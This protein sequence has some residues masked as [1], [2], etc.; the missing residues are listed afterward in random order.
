MNNL[1]KFTTAILLNP[2][3][4]LPY[5]GT[6]FELINPTE[7]TDWSFDDVF[8]S[9]FMYGPGMGNDRLLLI[10]KGDRQT[11]IILV[12]EKGSTI[13][14]PSLSDIEKEFKEVIEQYIYGKSLCY[15]LTHNVVNKSANK[16]QSSPVKLEIGNNCP[17]EMAMDEVIDDSFHQSMIEKVEKNDSASNGNEI[18]QVDIIK[19]LDDFL[20]WNMINITKG[21]DVLHIRD[22]EYHLILRSRGIGLTHKEKCDLLKKQIE[23]NIDLHGNELHIELLSFSDFE[24]ST[25]ERKKHYFSGQRC[26]TTVVGDSNKYNIIHKGTIYSEE[27]NRDKFISFK[28]SNI[29]KYYTIFDVF[30]IKLIPSK[31]ESVFNILLD[32]IKNIS[33]NNSELFAKIKCNSTAQETYIIAVPASIREESIGVI[34]NFN[35]THTSLKTNED[36]KNINFKIEYLSSVDFKKLTVDE[37]TKIVKKHLSA[38]LPNLGFG[39]MSVY[40]LDGMIK[41]FPVHSDYTFKKNVNVNEIV[42]FKITEI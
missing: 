34:R 11:L 9:S 42:L 18:T 37:K 38:K 13:T 32:E 7:G 27:I 20:F 40:N 17:V 19:K 25:Q 29:N 15:S 3:I 12:K 1:N 14:N 22:K 2:S 4:I 39:H 10:S 41:E 33:P 5:V 16:S 26:I 36:W 28:P 21:E 6:L 24:N 8:N 23:D 35:L 31:K 30:V